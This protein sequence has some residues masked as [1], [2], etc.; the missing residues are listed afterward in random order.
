MLREGG[1]RPDDRLAWA[2]REVTGRVPRGN[3][4]ALLRQL[5]DEQ[6]AVFTADPAAAEKLV[7]VGSLAITDTFPPVDLA[8]ATVVASSLFNL[9][10]SLMLR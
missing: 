7:K 6:L 8:A 9:D 1:T 4:G 5:Y 3:E 2:F 10:A